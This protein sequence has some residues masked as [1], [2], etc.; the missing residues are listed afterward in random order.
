VY[1]ICTRAR[2]VSFDRP[3]GYGGGA[4]DFLGNE[5]PLVRFAEQHGLDVTYA[6]DLTIEEHPDFLAHHTTLLSLGHD[7]CWSLGER[8]AAVAAEQHGLNIVFF[9]ASAV[10]RHV[11]PQP[12]PLGPDRELVDYRDSGADPLLGKVSPLEV[13]G[14]TW[15]SPPANWPEISFV[16]ERYSGFR[17]PGATP[18]PFVV[19]DGSAWIFSGTGLTTGTRVPDMLLSDF[20]QFDPE[21]HPADLQ[22]FAHSPIP[23]A[24][25]ESETSIRGGP[26]SDMT[27]YTDP[28][29]LAGVFDTGTNN[30]IPAMLPCAPALAP[31]PAG[32]VDQMTG[33]LLRTFARGPAGRSQ[34][35]VANWAQVY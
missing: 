21:E 12:S 20:D 7:E 32:V 33:N 13:T 25:T 34:P 15:S 23:R 4:A 35:S 16:G 27:Y 9:A 30:W 24:N 11:R 26:A 19:A 28:Q 17:E 5:Y 10:L 8:Q 2:V 31:C 18:S 6:T 22:I 29:S 3:Y 14:N 1:P